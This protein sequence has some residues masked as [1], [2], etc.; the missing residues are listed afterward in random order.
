MMLKEENIHLY[1]YFTYCFPVYFIKVR[2]GLIFLG[3]NDG[4]GNLT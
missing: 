2:M 4:D 3:G 1:F